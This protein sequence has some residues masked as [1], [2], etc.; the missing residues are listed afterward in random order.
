MWKKDNGLSVCVFLSLSAAGRSLS[1]VKEP[2]RCLP[3]LRAG[4][5]VSVNV[6]NTPNGVTEQSFGLL[7]GLFKVFL[8]RYGQRRSVQAAQTH[9]GYSDA[10]YSAGI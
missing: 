5:Q 1:G 9:A 8:L 6:H 2:L 4:L 3:M 10:G 7:L